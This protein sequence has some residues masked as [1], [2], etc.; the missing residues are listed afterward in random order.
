MEYSPAG[1][2]FV[3]VGTPVATLDAVTAAPATMAPEESV[4]MPRMAPVTV[5]AK[6]GQWGKR[7]TSAHANDLQIFFILFSPLSGISLPV[8]H[9]A[10]LS[11]DRVDTSGPQAKDPTAFQRST[12]RG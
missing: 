7:R 11:I 2:V 8:P 5:C 3:A 4:T 6:P 9:Q 1:F 10:L 12:Y